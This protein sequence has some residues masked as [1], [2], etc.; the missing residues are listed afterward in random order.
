[1]WAATAASY[2]PSRPGELPKLIA[3][4]Y[5]NQGDG[6]SCKLYLKATRGDLRVEV[7]KTKNEK[8]D[9]IEVIHVFRGGREEIQ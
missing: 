7:F 9:E 3:T 4:E 2:C 6:S 8:G 5:R 1:M